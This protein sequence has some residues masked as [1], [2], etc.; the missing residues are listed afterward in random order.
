[1]LVDILKC[2]FIGFFCSPPF[3]PVAVYVLMRSLQAGHRAGFTSGLGATTTDTLYAVIA[4]FALSFAQSFLSGHDAVILIAGGIIVAVLGLSMLLGKSSSPQIPGD[5]AQS[6][7]LPHY[8]KAVAMGISN[9]GAILIIF[10][11]F[12]FF[13]VYLGRGAY[14]LTPYILAFAGGSAAYWFCFTY[15]FSRLRGR[16][17]PRGMAVFNRIAAITVMVFGAVLLGKGLLNL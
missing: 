9:P 7:N 4:L 14:S 8:L 2:F 17:S 16:V 5:D 1:M 13:G 12:T 11:L 3:G 10:A 6:K 15:I